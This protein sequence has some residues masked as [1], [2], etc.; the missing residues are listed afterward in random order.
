MAQYQLTPEETFNVIQNAFQYHEIAGQTAQFMPTQ[1]KDGFKY[2]EER[3]YKTVALG[4]PIES[5]DLKQLHAYVA[6]L[7]Q[8]TANIVWHHMDL[9]LSLT[10]VLTTRG[11]A[12]D[13]Q[14]LSLQGIARQL[15][16]QQDK[17][18]YQGSARP[19]I[20]GLIA[21]AK[22]TSTYNTVKWG[23]AT[24]PSTTVQDMADSLITEG[25]F[26]PWALIIS[27]PLKGD[28]NNFINATPVSD[29]REKDSVNSLIGGP[30]FTEKGE[31]AVPVETVVYPLPAPA[32]TDGV[33]LLIK[34]EATSFNLIIEH[35][36]ETLIGPFDPR[37]KAWPISMIQAMT[38]QVIE[39][40]AIVNHADVDIA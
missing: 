28:L 32:S 23:A 1:V 15:A 31:I 19:A 5:R 37:R 8:S 11:T 40:G 38:L 13:I 3:W 6:A 36:I 27:D 17:F 35:P 14:A 29:I 25:F 10:D 26:E 34:P 12:F 18:V 21:S 9:E 4:R 22:N 2:Y 16:R 30:T 20:S 33:A 24:G 7:E 39:S